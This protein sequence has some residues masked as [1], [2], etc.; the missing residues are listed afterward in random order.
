M[1][2]PRCYEIVNTVTTLVEG[3]SDM[4]WVGHMGVP[5]C[6]NKCFISLKRRKGEGGELKQMLQ[7][8]IWGS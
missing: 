3:D 1:D 5:G 2:M 4:G 6:I 7:T 8:V